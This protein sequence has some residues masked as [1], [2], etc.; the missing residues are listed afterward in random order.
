MC[1]IHLGIGAVA[2]VVV[3]ISTEAPAPRIIVNWCVCFG[4]YMTKTSVL[5][6]KW[7]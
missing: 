1:C 4:N 7:E 5:S 6:S 2:A 3:V